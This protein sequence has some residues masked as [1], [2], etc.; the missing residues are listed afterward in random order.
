[1]CVCGGGGGATV[2]VY[3]LKTNFMKRYKNKP[4]DAKYG[5]RESNLYLTPA[6]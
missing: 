5:Q 2:R 3:A 1:M 4:C 6:F